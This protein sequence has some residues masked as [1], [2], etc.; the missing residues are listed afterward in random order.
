[1]EI[2]QRLAPS[3]V[4]LVILVAVIAAIVVLAR[5][6]G[7]AD[8]GESGIGTTRR[9][10][11]HSLSLAGL[12]AAGI[13][14]VLL[15]KAILD[16][17]FG[18]PAISVDQTTLALGLALTVV[19][20]PVWLLFWSMAQRSVRQ[21]PIEAASIAR[22]VTIN[23]ALGGSGIAASIGVVLFLAWLLG[24]GE[25]SGTPLALA[26]VWGGVWTFYW[27]VEA[28]EGQPTETA[29]SIHRFYVYGASLWGLALLGVGVVGVLRLAL[30]AAYDALF[31]GATLLGGSP[32]L[33]NEGMQTAMSLALVG[34]GVWWWHWHRVAAGDVASVLRN[35]Y[36]YLFAVLGGAATVVA[37]LTVLLYH[38][39]QWFLGSP[40]TSVARDHFDVAPVL[41]A[42]IAVGGGLWGYHWAVL[43][44]EATVAGRGLVA[45]RRVYGYLVAAVGLVVLGIGL[46]TLVAVALGLLAP[47]RQVAGADWWRNPLVLAITL[48]VMGAPVW[49][50]YWRD[51]QRM[52]AEAGHAE[53]AALSR[54]VFVYLIFGA[55]VLLALVNLSII[56]FR[57]F[58][59]ALG[60]ELPSDLL[61]DTRWSIGILLTAGAVSVYYWL[62]LREDRRAAAA[63]EEA[64]TPEVPSPVEA[65]P[66]KRVTALVGEEGLPLVRRLEARLGYSVQVWQPTGDGGPVPALS[67]EELTEIGRQ[68]SEADSD[69]VLLLVDAEGMR[70]VPYRAA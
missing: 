53:R 3:L 9:L 23:L 56:L 63:I 8:E 18:P 22:K 6:H 46:V 27:Q 30:G 11:L 40:E 47:E 15:L 21:H 5:R 29:A 61:W 38:V 34:G 19:G 26:L 17:L 2:A 12:V 20:T 4:S 25:F 65:R 10:Y 55:S 52:A 7:G 13:G 43:R 62:V 60:G 32:D 70:V 39:L 37:S 28:R 50:L 1:M 69:H 48:L 33:W 42:A 31:G 64:R 24:V 41:V 57:L 16:S 58:D 45:A 35:V 67:D 59:A 68:V 14:A 51:I 36:L 49:G 54:R 44:Q 66:R